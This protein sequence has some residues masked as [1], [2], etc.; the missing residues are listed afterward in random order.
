MGI[1]W[2]KD[3]SADRE[4]DAAVSSYYESIVPGTVH[5][6]V[7]ADTTGHFGLVVFSLISNPLQ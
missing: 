6:V 1:C 4:L 2:G 3:V 5:E 7:I